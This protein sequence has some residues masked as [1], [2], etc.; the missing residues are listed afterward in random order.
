M[1]KFVE[2]D[3]RVSLNDQMENQVLS[4]ENSIFQLQLIL[5]LMVTFTLLKEEMNAF[6]KLIPLENHF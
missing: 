1:T 3:D 6:K 2:I 4:L 5:I